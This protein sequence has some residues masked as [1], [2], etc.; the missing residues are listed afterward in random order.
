MLAFLFGLAV[1]ASLGTTA[2]IG[3]DVLPASP[4]VMAIVFVAHGV[5]ALG[6][7]RGYGGYRALHRLVHEGRG[8][9]YDLA[10]RRSIDKA[11]FREFR[12]HFK[13]RRI[14][15]LALCGLGL[16]ALEAAEEHRPLASNAR[17]ST[18]LAAAAA[19]AEANLCLGQ[20]EW[21]RVSLDRVLE[22]RGHDEHPGIRAMRGRLAHC[23]G[24][25]A[26]AASLLKAVKGAGE[27]PVKGAVTARNHT[28]YADALQGLGKAGEAAQAYRTAARVAP[29]SFWGAQAVRKAAALR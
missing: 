14:E 6:F 3:L 13:L 11:R 10:V 25:H 9:L 18:R 20:L 5:F 17:V 4:L 16:R 15:G 22:V 19:E 7:F 29:H 12:D 8:E 28:W 24:D 21:A 27:W 1:L 26:G 2:L 23:R